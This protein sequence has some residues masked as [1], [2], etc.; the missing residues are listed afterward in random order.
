MLCLGAPWCFAQCVKGP[1]DPIV[2]HP[3]RPTVSTSAETTQCGVLE[4][5]YGWTVQWPEADVTESGL[6]GM[7]RLGLSSRLDLRWSTDGYLGRTGLRGRQSGTGDQWL[8]TQY[9]LRRESGTAPALALGYAVKF[10]GALDSMGSAYWDHRIALI[11][12]KTIGEMNWNLNATYV[13]SGA[14]GNIDRNWELATGFSRPVHG[15]LSVAG[16]VYVD[17]RRNPEER[18]FGSTLW[19]V[20]Y[21]ASPRLILDAGVNLGLTNETARRRV[22]VGLTY[23]LADLHSVF[24][25]S[26][27]RHDRR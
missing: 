10:P 8:G 1:E 24:S 21:A 3:N 19:A 23:A 17:T 11:A 25:S 22:V 20:T 2:A 16:D 26:I 9:F 18:A 6:G 12:S 27:W 13:L 4:V 15:H 7:M 5:E 14:E